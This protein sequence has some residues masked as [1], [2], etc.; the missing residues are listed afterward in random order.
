MYRCIAVLACLL[1]TVLSAAGEVET[2]GQYLPQA[3]ACT[4]SITN[5]TKTKQ[6]LADLFH[7]RMAFAGFYVADD[8]LAKRS[9]KAAFF[10]PSNV[11]GWVE[12]YGG[13]PTND[14][15]AVLRNDARIECNGDASIKQSNL[16]FSYLDSE[17]WVSKTAVITCEDTPTAAKVIY[18]CLFS[19]SSNRFGVGNGSYY[20][21]FSSSPVVE[22]RF[23]SEISRILHNIAAK[24]ASTSK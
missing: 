2:P 21:V 9:P 11:T 17:G 15:S 18:I 16:D 7:S 14:F 13:C 23:F 6:W 4:N 24:D 20:V 5:A 22:R 10:G 8:A 1:G 3:Q 19:L 12:L